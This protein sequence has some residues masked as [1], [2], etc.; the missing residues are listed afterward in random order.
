MQCPEEARPASGGPPGA[1]LCPENWQGVI[2][3]LLRRKTSTL[4]HCANSA[5]CLVPRPAPSAFAGCLGHT[6]LQLGGIVHKTCC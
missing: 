3:V 2:F 5:A 4:R 6:L 1:S